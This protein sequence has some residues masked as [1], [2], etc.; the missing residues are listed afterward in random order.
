MCTV[1]RPNYVFH[2]ILEFVQSR[3][4]VTQY[5]NFPAFIRLSYEY[6]ASKSKATCTVVSLF[7]ALQEVAVLAT[8]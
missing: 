5:L 3:D 4:C 7:T 1:Y 2:A 8:L 6:K